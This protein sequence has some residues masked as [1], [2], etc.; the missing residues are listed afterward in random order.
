MKRLADD[1]NQLNQNNQP[2]KDAQITTI[3]RSMI[4]IVSTFESLAQFKRE[5]QSKIPVLA[6]LPV[7]VEEAEEWKREL[8]SDSDPVL[9]LLQLNEFRYN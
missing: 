4:R 2:I 1:I 6:S 5:K 3:N 9:N 8:G 7:S